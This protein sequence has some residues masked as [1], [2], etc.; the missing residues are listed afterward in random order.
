MLIL[1]PA[2]HKALL[3]LENGADSV[4]GRYGSYIPQGP[5]DLQ[6]LTLELQPL[7]QPPHHLAV[8][9]TSLHSLLLTQTQVRQDREREGRMVDLPREL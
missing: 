4:D 7:L 2:S 8:L 3:W 6:I 1:S 5:S 9:Q